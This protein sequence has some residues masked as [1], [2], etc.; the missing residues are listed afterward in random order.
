MTTPTLPAYVTPDYLASL[1]LRA[2][3]GTG[4]PGDR[5]ALQEVRAWLGL[6]AASDKIPPCVCPVIGPL[7]IRA[8]DLDAATRAALVPLLPRLLGSRGSPALDRRRRWALVD[9][10][11][12]AAAP[13]RLDAIAAREG[14]AE[15]AATRIRGWSLR[16]ASLPPIVDAAS[17][18]AARATTHTVRDE[19]FA[20][21]DDDDDA[22]ADAADDDDAA[23]YDAASATDR[24]DLPALIAHLLDLAEAS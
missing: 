22:D 1:T 18:A 11:I 5:C 6:P 7:A 3:L 21:A 13:V 8:N 16:L 9:W 14:L 23:A 19:A 2:G 12:R 17:F 15:N 4:A 10:T 20:A 24:A